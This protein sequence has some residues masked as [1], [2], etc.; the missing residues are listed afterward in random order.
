MNKL[1]LRYAQE[2]HHIV[3][4]VL[5]H[6]DVGSD[7]GKVAG[8]EPNKVYIS[9]DSDAVKVIIETKPDICI[10]ATRSTLADIAPSLRILGIHGINTVTIGEEAFFGWNTSQ[11]LVEELDGLYKSKSA[12]LTGT[13]FQDIF[14]GYLPAALVR[15]THRVERVEG[16]ARFNVDDY[17]SALCQ[18]HGV[19]LSQEQFAE[20]FTNNKA[21]GPSYVWNSNEWL[22]S[23]LGWTLKN[24]RQVLLP[25]LADKEIYS[26]SLKSNI[27]A[28]HAT[29]LKA[30]VTSETVDGIIIET[31]M[32][33][34]VYHGGLKDLC[35]WVVKG[36]PET[37]L[38]ISIPHTVES[39]C[40][41]AVNRLH[42][43]YAAAPGYVTSD[44]LG[45]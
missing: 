5:G 2:K 8:I 43:V 29:G 34:E 25:T 19:G 22:V 6:H 16:T 4:G 33:C 44:K 38:V 14:W 17:G 30:I 13:G 28:H 42:Q 32:I 3:V 24:T 1:I 7:A 21:V 20:Q 18:A 15:G 11:K 12:T 45:L 39:T 9:N 31:T 40:A 41:S 26:K 23:C 35:T 10:L 27:P 36:E 37:E